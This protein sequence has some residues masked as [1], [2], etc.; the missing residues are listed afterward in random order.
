MSELSKED[1]FNKAYSIVS[2]SDGFESKCSEIKKY[3][4][5]LLSNPNLTNK[6]PSTLAEMALK[7]YENAEEEI[8]YAIVNSFIEE[9]F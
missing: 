1:I 6:S 2:G 7:H 9:R 3:Y 4:M 5:A 8:V